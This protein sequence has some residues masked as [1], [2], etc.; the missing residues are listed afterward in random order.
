MSDLETMDEYAMASAIA[1]CNDL[2]VFRRSHP[3]L[4]ADLTE[5]FQAYKSQFP[6]QFK[7]LLVVYQSVTG[8][9]VTSPDLTDY[10]HKMWAAVEF[11][12]KL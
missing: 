11:L 6:T 10:V 2:D 9:G 1:I 5:S 12:E 8:R 3:G 7:E 4:Q